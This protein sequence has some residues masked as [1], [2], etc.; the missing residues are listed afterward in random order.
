MNDQPAGGANFPWLKNYPPG[1]NW[2]ASLPVAP[3]TK[4]VD[5][6]TAKYPDSI[7]TIFFDKQHT[8]REIGDMIDR[9]A[10]GFQAL[11][12]KKGTKVGICLPNCTYYVILYFGVLRAGGTVVNFNPLYVEHELKF[13]IEDS[14]TE[15]MCTLDLKALYD[16]L[17]RVMKQTRLKKILVCRFADQLPGLKKL[18]FPLARRKDIAKVKYDDRNMRYAELVANDGKYTPV[19]IDPKEDVAILQY[20]GGTTGVPKGAMLTHANLYI[21][22]MQVNE[23]FA[24]RP[25]G[26]ERALAILPF[27]HVYGMT[28]ILNYSLCRGTTMILVPR[29][30]VENV[31]KVIDKH[32]P[33]IFAGVPTMYNAILNFKDIKQYDLSSLEFC[34]AGGAALPVETMRSWKTL[35][36][37]RIC[38]GYGLTESSP[39]AVAIPEHGMQ[40]EASIGVPY[41]NT[42]IEIVDLQDPHKKMPAGERGELTIRGPQVMKG[43]WK[44]PQATAEVIVD[45]KLLTGDIAY[46]DEDGYV[47]IVDRKK[48]MIIA[49]G[50][51]V[52]PRQVEEAIY[53]HP[54][55]E[56]C[57]VVGVPDPYRGQNV[58]A[59]VKLRD[60]AALTQQEL[61]EFLKDR[62]SP[63]EM[64][65]FV[66]FTGPLP[67]S[68]IGKILKKELIAQDAVKK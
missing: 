2:A 61:D 48:E 8:Y 64:P 63:I 10:K 3:L 65:K 47:F 66:E 37:I 36:G 56:E 34:S 15:I 41:P 22:C 16:K 62:I 30:E 19:A 1:V 42:I 6:V 38:E 33:T 21:N 25:P 7:A 51:K 39:V 50:Y 58:K 18:L 45:G 57:A 9:A 17:E 13:Q 52:Y 35:T 29:F 26:G 44:K 49:S 23:W 5:D 46:M 68:A 31:V 14:E 28:A 55:V 60:G 53:A 20:T 27:F 32:K 43:Y 67:K 59:Y 11:G 24:Y 12:V 4:L 40:K 54:A